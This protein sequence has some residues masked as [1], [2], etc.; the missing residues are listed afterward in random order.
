MSAIIEQAMQRAQA[1]AGGAAEPVAQ[2]GPLSVRLLGADSAERARWDAFVQ[3]C[4]EATFFHR[5]GWQRVIE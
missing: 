5:A 3:D 4:P 2:A 1:H